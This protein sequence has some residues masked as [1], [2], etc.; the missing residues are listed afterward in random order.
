[1][2][3]KKIITKLYVVLVVLCSCSTLAYA[4]S[5]AES[6]T[7][8][9]ELLLEEMVDRDCIA[10]LPKPA[11]T[12][13]QFSSYDRNS[14]EPGSPTWWANSDRSYFVRIEDNNGRKEHVLMDVGGPGAVVRFWATWHGPGG[15]EF[16]NGTLR[17]YLDKK[18]KPVIEGPM[19]DL[20]SGGKLVAEPLSQ[21]V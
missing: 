7:I 20:I 15:G 11:Y 3:Q 21:G 5:G 1:M 12:C 16:S 19:A 17:V 8:N 13:R 14:T 6:K 4:A 10:R 2:K 18:A 9:F